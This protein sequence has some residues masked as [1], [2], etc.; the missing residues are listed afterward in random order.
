M[1]DPLAGS[2]ALLRCD[3][4]VKPRPCPRLAFAGAHQSG[5]AL[6]RHF[7]VLAKPGHELAIEYDGFK[8]FD[9]S[10]H[11]RLIARVTVEVGENARGKFV[12]G[13]H[14]PESRFDR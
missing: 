9:Y 4:V 3:I 11:G 10:S 5:P 6:S 14:R 7:E 2:A 12:R 1:G 13:E 8:K